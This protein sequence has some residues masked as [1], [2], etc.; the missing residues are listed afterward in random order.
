MK[1]RNTYM[2]YL[3]KAIH[4][5]FIFFLLV[6]MITSCKNKTDSKKEMNAYIDKLSKELQTNIESKE[7]MSHKYE[8]NVEPFYDL[9]MHPIYNID[10]FSEEQLHT[11]EKFANMLLDGYRENGNQFE[12]KLSEFVKLEQKEEQEKIYFSSWEKDFSSIF[13]D[14]RF[15]IY[16]SDSVSMECFNDF[17]IRYESINNKHY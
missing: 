7:T 17:L 5:I 13:T 2:V 10:S 15:C 4:H 9:I 14:L 8:N 1:Q 6:F 11:Y 3:S 12:E 16:K